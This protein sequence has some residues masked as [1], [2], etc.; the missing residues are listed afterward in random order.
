M[1]TEL[2]HV[3]GYPVRLGLY[4]DP[5]THLWVDPGPGGV[6]R[7]GLDPLGVET[8]G[9]LVRL[10]LAQPGQQLARGG[11]C[12]SLE[13]AKFVGPLASPLT[14]VVQRANAEVAA[15]PGVVER[16]PFGAGW[17]LEVRTTCWDDEAP[18]LLHEPRQVRDWFAAAVED[19]RVKG[20]LAQ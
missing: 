18:L 13:A 11:S 19:Y 20:V 2:I 5:D 3:A 14:G 6:A 17:L 8:T 10:A 7:V 1:S 12:G 4:Y 15:D 9:T 16:D